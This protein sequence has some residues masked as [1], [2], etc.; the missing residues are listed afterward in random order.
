MSEIKKDQINFLILAGGNSSRIQ[1]KF[2]GKQ[3]I[4]LDINNKPFIGYLLEKI[5]S[6][7][8]TKVVISLGFKAKEPK[9]IIDQIKPDNIEISYVV[10][11]EKL[12]TG[13]AIFNS[14]SSIESDIF[15]V[16]N[17]DS[18]TNYPFCDFL[19]RTQKINANFSML[20]TRV[21]DSSRY[22]TVYLQDNKISSFVEKRN[23]CVSGLINAG[24]YI[25]KKSR[26]DRYFEGKDKE[27]SLEFDVF[28][29]IIESGEIYGIVSER[30]FIDI[31]IPEDFQRARIFFQDL[32]FKA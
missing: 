18:Y 24:C 26:I 29:E 19:S 32:D 31:G 20:L 8:F 1:S 12:G 4:T 25:F 5:S 2:P 6:E 3:K 9:K 21:A 11:N 23:V 22:G 14:L 17:G 15:F 27:F 7:G 16:L 13:G 10:E 30:E 28:P